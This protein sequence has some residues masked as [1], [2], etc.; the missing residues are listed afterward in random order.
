MLF[1][2]QGMGWYA[3]RALGQEPAERP[4]RF[5]DGF[6]ENFRRLERLRRLA[7]DTGRNLSEL[8]TAYVMASGLNASVL[9]AYSTP[10]QLDESFG[11]LEF[12]LT[13]EQTAYLEGRK[14]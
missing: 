6:P 2:A 10:R 14:I 3:R 9:C 1:G 13:P 12:S 8:T 5:F 11:A 4:R 7:A